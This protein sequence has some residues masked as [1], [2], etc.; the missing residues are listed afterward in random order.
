MR[1]CSVPLPAAASGGMRSSSACSVVQEEGGGL[2]GFRAG[3]RLDLSQRLE[4]A[5]ELRRRALAPGGGD[6]AVRRLR[7]EGRVLAGRGEHSVQFR[8]ARA[9]RAGEAGVTGKLVRLVMDVLVGQAHRLDEAG[10]VVLRVLPGVA[11]VLHEFLRHDHAVAGTVRADQRHLAEQFR[12]VGIAGSGEEA[13]HLH[14]GIEAVHHPA[15]QLQDDLLADNDRAVGLFGGKAAN[16]GRVRQLHLLQDAG[17]A[18][19]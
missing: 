13:H 8:Q 11:L 9:D 3:K 17:S 19:R 14:L 5:G 18:G 16:L 2:R 4:G 6:G 1:V 10:Q 15:E 12:A 7:R